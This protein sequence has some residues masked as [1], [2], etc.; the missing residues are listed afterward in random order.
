MIKSLKQ[1]R[2]FFS[3]DP[4]IVKKDAVIISMDTSSE[5]AAPA[6]VPAPVAAPVAAHVSA[7]AE[8]SANGN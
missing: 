6:P 1:V 5:P 7:P 3:G 4:K 2:W 8:S